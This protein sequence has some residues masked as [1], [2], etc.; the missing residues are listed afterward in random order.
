METKTLNT[1]PFFTALQAGATQAI[2]KGEYLV[3]ISLNSAS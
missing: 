3:L 2:D 1:L